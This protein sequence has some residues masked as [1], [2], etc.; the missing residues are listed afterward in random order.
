MSV[1]A[2]IRTLRRMLAWRV[3]Q[4]ERTDWPPGTGASRINGYWR[5]RKALEWALAQLEPLVS[6]SVDPGAR[7][8]VHGSGVGDELGG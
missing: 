3:Q 6:P 1:A 4:T 8:Q 2:K 7:L 5:E